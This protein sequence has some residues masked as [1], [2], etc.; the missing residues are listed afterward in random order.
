MPRENPSSTWFRLFCFQAKKKIHNNTRMKLGDKKRQLLFLTAC[1][2]ARLTVACLTLF[3]LPSAP[4]WLNFVAG[5]IFLVAA[6]S[7]LSFVVGCRSRETGAFGGPCYWAPARLVHAILFLAAGI[8]CLLP[9]AQTTIYA[10]LLLLGD[11]SVGLSNFLV[12][13]EIRPCVRL[14]A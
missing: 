4:N 5:G 7:W 6:F 9:G 14:D 10:G 3:L 12:H 8:L 13:Y 2:P 1:L 11:V